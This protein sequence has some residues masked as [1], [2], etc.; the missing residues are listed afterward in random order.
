VHACVDDVQRPG[1]GPFSDYF[2]FADHPLTNNLF[3]NRQS[4]EVSS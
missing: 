4:F 3:F 2:L 1:V